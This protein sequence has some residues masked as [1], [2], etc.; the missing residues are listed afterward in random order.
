MGCTTVTH[1]DVVGRLDLI[2][3]RN[4]AS[5]ANT[6]CYLLLDRFLTDD[7]AP[8]ATPRTSEPGPGTLTI[9]QPANME[10]VNNRLVA[11]AGVADKGAT[12]ISSYA[13]TAGRAFGVDVWGI[14]GRVDLLVGPSPGEYD[15]EIIGGTSVLFVRGPFGA[16]NTGPFTTSLPLTAWI[17]RRASGGLFYIVSNKLRWVHNGADVANWFVRLNAAVSGWDF[18]VDDLRIIDFDGLWSQ[19]YG[20]ATNRVAS[21]TSGV[22]TTSTADAL[23]EFTWTPVAA[24]TLE[25]DVR[26]TDANNRWV[27]RCDQAGATIK[28]IERNAGAETERD[29]DAQTW[30]PGTPYRIVVAMEGADMRNFVNDTAQNAY[31]SATFNQTATGVQVSGFTTGSNLICWP[32]DLTYIIPPNF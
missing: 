18:I 29:S 26:R 6:R 32:R 23:V 10:I 17:V 2:Q 28:L 20:I 15:I 25:F 3:A 1:A 14:N 4:D 16:L 7:A 9:N 24:E 12:S 11:L 19:E 30:T 27:I 31:T 13:Y 8:L 5:R 21:P 22:S